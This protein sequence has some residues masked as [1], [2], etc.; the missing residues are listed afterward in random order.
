MVGDGFLVKA[1]AVLRIAPVAVGFGKIRFQPD[2][3]VMVGD[4]FLVKAKAV[5]G[6]APVAVGFGKIRFQPD[7]FVMVG[8]GFLVKAKAVLGNA[9]VAVGFGKIRFQPDRFVTVG[10]GFLVKAKAV[11]HI[12]PVAVDFGI[13]RLQPDRLVM[14][15]DGFLMPTKI[16]LGNT[17]VA[18]DF[19]IVRLQPDRFVMVG[20]GFLVKA[21]AV[22][23]NA[24]V[25][26]GCDIVRLQPNRLI[27]GMHNLF[28]IG[29]FGLFLIEIAD[30]KPR[31]GF[32]IVIGSCNDISDGPPLP[33]RVLSPALP[34]KRD[35]GSD[36]LA[37]RRCCGIALHL[38]RSLPGLVGIVI[39][40]LSGHFPHMRFCRI[41]TSTGFF[42]KLPCFFGMLLGQFRVLASFG[43]Q[44][45]E[46]PVREKPAQSAAYCDDNA[47]QRK[48]DNRSLEPPIEHPRPVVQHLAPQPVFD[49]QDFVR[50]LRA[51][52]A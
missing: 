8:D 40:T 34:L 16:V 14:V 47:K 15:R 3:F 18:V 23:G 4:G 48:E 19:G 20:D 43:F 6:N 7:R 25:V 29:F 31:P 28:Q 26:V 35:G 49:L 45:A 51:C 30:G 50:R 24:P 1:K 42:D 33:D 46:P 17:P 2:R 10:D 13:V 5:L 21:K 39:D 52:I 22:L 44:V 27:V 11:L 12:A 36:L 9:P 37:Y 32:D 41:P 38:F